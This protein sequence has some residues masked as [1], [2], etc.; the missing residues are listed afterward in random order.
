MKKTILKLLSGAI[1]LSTLGTGASAMALGSIPIRNK[2]SN[3]ES[4]QP[5]EDYGFEDAL[6][7]NEENAIDV[8]YSEEDKVFTATP[9]FD[10]VPGAPVI[11]LSSSQYEPD[12]EE[13]EIAIESLDI[14]EV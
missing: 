1:M 8:N 2:S 6:D 10:G 14:S 9:W 7:L 12:E 3:E 4:F 11:I 13:S 5:S